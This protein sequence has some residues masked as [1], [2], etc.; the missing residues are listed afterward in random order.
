M[1]SRELTRTECKEIRQLV[2]NMCANYDREN[3]CLQLNDTCY[4][5]YGVAHTNSPLCNYFRNA[6]LPTNPTLEALMTGSGTFDMR[7][8]GMCGEYFSSHSKKAYCSS[9]CA[10]KAQRK[11]QREYMRKKRGMC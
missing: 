2:K 6:V 8:C 11:Q 3:G 7:D 1:R 4:M 9:E 10:K 5:L